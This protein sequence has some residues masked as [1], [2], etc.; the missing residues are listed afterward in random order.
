MTLR[1]FFR[2]PARLDLDEAAEWYESQQL[3]LGLGAEFISEI[4]AALVQACDAPQRF[5]L[6]VGDVRRVRVRR[7]PYSILFR[8]R[9][10]ALIVLS[11]FHARRDPAT[12]RGRR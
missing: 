9:S 5:P 8:V 3:G 7:F 11:V 4:E 2:R 1:P 12:W 6:V 10:N